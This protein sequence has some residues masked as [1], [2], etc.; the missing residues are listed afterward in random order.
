MKSLLHGSL[1]EVVS[2]H[3]VKLIS[4]TGGADGPIGRQFIAHPE[5]EMQYKGTGESDPYQENSYEIAPGLVYKFR[6][7]VHKDGSVDYYGRA[8]W[9]ISRYCA[10]YC[11][12]CMRGR[13]V[14][15]PSY[16]QLKSNSALSQK[17][18]L[19]EV[20][21][22]EVYSFIRS[23]PELNEIILSGG[24]P[25]VNTREYL[26][27]I[28]HSL[29]SLQKE[30]HL[31]I[32]RIGTRLPVHN[33]VL[34]KEWH[35]ELIEQIKNP[36]IMLH[37]NHPA[38]LTAESLDVLNHMRKAGATIM[39]QTVLLKGVNDSVGTLQTLFNTLAR[40]GIRPYYLFQNDPVYWAHHFT[41]PF[42]EALTLWSQLRKRLSGVAATAKFIIEP[43]GGLGKI[44]VPESG[45]WDFQV[46]AYDDFNGMTH[47]IKA[48]N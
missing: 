3:L 39:S 42:E 11:R 28:V 46:D 6:G 4:T 36:Y 9:T 41:V 13:E 16:V 40:E 21:R 25:F 20:D 44:P 33:P 47:E 31:D 8:L 7:K 1:P 10:S 18:H 12:F 5:K 24:D 45:A 15:L 30:K 32:I 17:S 35:Y 14:G 37:V 29:S 2:S 22:E 48:R 27:S 26:S 34:F 23:N 19:S 43:M 38:E